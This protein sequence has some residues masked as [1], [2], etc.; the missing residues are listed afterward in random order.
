M[1]MQVI[2]QHLPDAADL[3]LHFDG[4]LASLL[5]DPAPSAAKLDLFWDVDASGLVTID[6]MSELF[7]ASTI[8]RMLAAYQ[9]LLQQAAQQPQRAVTNLRL[10]T[11]HDRQLLSR[12]SSGA[13]RPDYLEQPLMPAAF[14]ELA[15]AHPSR[16]CLVFGDEVLTYGEVRQ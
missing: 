9:L 10:L 11:E 8:E 7:D 6:Y 14:E 4:L 5:P 12:L 13:L 2:F 16:P 15:A 1:I 3:R